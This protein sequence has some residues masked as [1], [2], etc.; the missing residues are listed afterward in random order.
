MY[1]T[2]TAYWTRSLSARDRLQQLTS[3]HPHPNLS[4]DEAILDDQT[5][6]L[7]DDSHLLIAT[8][9][10]VLLDIIGQGALYHHLTSCTPLRYYIY[11]F[12]SLYRDSENKPNNK[13]RMT[14]TTTQK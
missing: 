10:L 12:I 3:A 2:N 6:R 11:I 8:Q 7:L 13:T 1:V 9:R 14:R 4:G 5:R